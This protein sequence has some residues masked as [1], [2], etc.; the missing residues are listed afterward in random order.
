MAV[1]P[2]L[3]FVWLT[4]SLKFLLIEVPSHDEQTYFLAEGHREEEGIWLFSIT[5]IP[6]SRYKTAMVSLTSD[7]CKF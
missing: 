5:R 3:I 2:L 1:K 6:Y 4:S 7:F